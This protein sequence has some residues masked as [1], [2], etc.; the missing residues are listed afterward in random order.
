MPGIDPRKPH[1]KKKCGAH[2]RTTGKPCERWAKKG[3]DRCRRHGGA[4]PKGVD[5]PQRISS[6]KHGLYAKTFSKDELEFAR[7][8][9]GEV[10]TE[11]KRLLHGLAALAAAKLMTVAKKQD[12]DGMV[13]SR[14]SDT[15]K[16]EARRDEDGEIVYDRYVDGVPAPDAK[17]VMV[18]VEQTITVDKTDVSVPSTDLSMKIARLLEAA[19]SM[20][21]DEL[22]VTVTVER[23]LERMLEKLRA[24]LT[25][26]EYERVLSVA[27]SE[28]GSA[29]AE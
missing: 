17:P 28:G 2:C 27:A 24:S 14:H 19:R 1:R 11:P 29:E 5:A 20:D 8:W 26:E 21:K 6:L 25:P 15:S 18:P 9:L 10:E 4:T 13:V 7:Q 22:R 12:K 23:E 16:V 3:S